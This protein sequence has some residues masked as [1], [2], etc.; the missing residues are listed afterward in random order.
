M[1]RALFESEFSA[2]DMAE[3]EEMYARSD[4]AVFVIDRGDGSLGGFVE[5]GSRSVVDGCRTSPVG[6]LEAWYVDE[7]LRRRGYGANLIDAAEQWSRDQGYSEMGS[8]ALIDNEVSHASHRALGYEEVSR[9][10]TYRKSL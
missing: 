3:M 5:A 10:I 4:A 7:D 6:Y 2:D 1:S 9:V 8:D